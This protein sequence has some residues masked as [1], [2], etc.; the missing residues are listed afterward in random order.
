M[1]KLMQKLNNRKG[2]GYIDIVIMVIAVLMVVVLTI[3]IYGFFTLK[4]QMDEIANQLI[5][6]ATLTGAFD[7]DFY[8]LVDSL[9]AQHENVPFTVDVD[10][11]KWFNS[12]LRQVQYGGTMTVVVRSAR[13]LNAG[14]VVKMSI[15]VGV[16]RSG[17]SRGNFKLLTEAPEEP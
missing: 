8:A 13:V 1:R 7:S 4:T 6:Q 17:L 2:E 15:P 9:Q 16:S 12:G 5:D 14:G 3:S 10:A 11:D